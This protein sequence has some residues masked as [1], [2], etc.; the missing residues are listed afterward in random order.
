[1]RTTFF[2]ALV[3][4]V[5]ACGGAAPPRAEPAEPTSLTPEPA[6]GS[7][8]ALGR[9][10]GAAAGTLDS[11][12]CGLSKPA[13]CDRF[14]QRHASGGRMG[15]L[16]P[17]RWSAGRVQ[18]NLPSGAGRAMPITAATLPAC[19]PGLPARVFPDQD[20]LI[21]AP[22]AGIPNSHLLV[23]VAAQNYG[24]NSYRIRQPFDFAG[25]TGTIVFD[26]DPGMV[27]GMGP[28]GWVSIEVTEDPVAVPSYALFM[29]DE[30]GAKPKNGFELQLRGT[31]SGDPTTLGLE[32]LHVFEDY[33]A[34]VVQESNGEF[35]KLKAGHLNRFQ[36]RVSRERV[37]LAA[38]DY[39]EDGERFGPF[40]RLSSQPLDVSFTRGYVHVSM[41][42]HASEKY[43]N[44]DAVFSRW[45]NVGF[46][47]PVVTGW[48][49]YDA[50]DS[51]VR[52]GDTMD[53]GYGASPDERPV[54]LTFP[55]VDTT[56]ATRA[57]LALTAWYLVEGKG[58]SG[59]ALRYRFNG[60][61]WHDHVL[62]QGEQ[63]SIAKE[64]L[65]TVDHVLDVPIA[66]LVPGDNRIE[67]TTANAPSHYPPVLANVTLIVAA[68]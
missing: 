22:T 26:V 23:A 15:E 27:E 8:L 1:M 68:E 61:R 9:A 5:S 67:L 66:E 19:R 57:R 17:A 36:L 14:D 41:H 20:T 43:A 29:N 28:P 49:E 42:N 62:T 46:D 11:G 30:G 12:A 58:P 60:K 51:R 25:R 55:G 50:P 65:G 21:C 16:D 6:R 10:P 40:K 52:A 38:T 37:E 45:D 18:P 44:M 13:F 64:A 2:S 56:S 53:I 3:W 63:A 32:R 34:R 33:V 39:S 4:M 35:V 31:I 7:S 47:G 59:Y 24:Q 48:R 54:S